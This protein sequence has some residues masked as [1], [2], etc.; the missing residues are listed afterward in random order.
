M[1][2][3]RKGFWANAVAAAAVFA[4]GGSATANSNTGSGLTSS[5]GTGAGVVS[6]YDISATS[7]TLN[8]ANP[9]NT[10]A[11][12]ITY[13]GSPVPVS[14]RV[15]PT[16]ASSTYYYTE[17]ANPSGNRCTATATVITC[18]TNT[19]GGGHQGTV[20]ELTNLTVV[21]AQ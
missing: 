20:L 4:V 5:A 17:A 16:G 18:L 2:F 21:L 8:S 7:Y 14:I 15:S 11:I 12:V 13:S 10:D 9:Q 1:F 6:G 19:T 3:L